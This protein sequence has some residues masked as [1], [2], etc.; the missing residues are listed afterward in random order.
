MHWLKLNDRSKLH[1]ICADKL[2]V[3]DY[4]A[5]Q[6]GEKYLIPLLYST[7]KTSEITPK[8]LPDFP[9]IIKTNHDSGSTFIINNKKE[10]DW[11]NLRNKLQNSLNNNFYYAGREWPYKHIPPRIIIEKLI[12]QKD[13]S[14]PN[15][16]KFYCSN[17]VV[18]YIQIEI[19]RGG[20]G[21]SRNIYDLNWNLLDINRGISASNNP[22]PRPK[23]LTEMISLCEKLSAPFLFARVDLYYVDDELI[24][25]GEI[26]FTPAG[27]LTP[28]EP[29]KWDKIFGD[30]ISLPINN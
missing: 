11:Q 24:Y 14:I 6:I 2:L 28:F 25:F 26:T 29:N 30:T 13:D 15:D 4:V 18:H 20:S 9:V 5:E 17:G 23:R 19:D 21:H 12:T 22:E 1:T 7:K 16:Y 27:G 8:K 10:Y 3:R